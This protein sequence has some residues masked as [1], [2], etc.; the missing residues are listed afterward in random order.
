MSAGAAHRRAAG[1]L[2][3]AVL[4]LLAAGSAAAAADWRAVV[5]ELFP[6]A[7]LVGEMSGEPPVAE[8]RAGAEVVGHV[9][10]T[11]R[12]APVPAYSGEPI[13]ALLGIGAGGRLRG[14]RIVAHQ[15]PILA[16]GVSDRQLAE[17]VAQYRGLPADVRIQVGGGAREG[18]TVIDGLSGATITAMSV[19]ASIQATARQSAAALG[20]TGAAE[21]VEPV[22]KRNWRE[23]RWEIAVLLAALGLL[24]TVLVFQDAFARR[25]RL[26]TA[27]RRG[28]LVFTLGFIGWYALAQLSVVN[29]F[30]F[31]HAATGEFRWETF[32]VDPLLFLLWGFVAVAMLL[33]GRG[34]YCGWLC[35]Y[36]ALQELASL[37]GRRLGL[38]QWRFPTAVHDRLWALKYVLFL[39]LFGLALQSLVTVQPYL[40]VEPFKTAITLRFQREWPFVAY[41]ALFVLVSMFNPKFYCKYVCPLGAALAI[42]ARLRL[43]DWLRRRKECGRPCQVCAVE[44]D[45]QAIRATGEINVN[46]CH[47]CLDCQLLYYDDHRCPPLAERRRRREKSREAWEKVRASV[48]AQRT[49]DD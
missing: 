32:L 35:P 18:Y 47:H 3:A 24:T 26:V 23:R 40:E 7:T 5:P 19:D 25:P 36:G 34:V 31:L 49:G 11:D 30:T 4:T 38:P 46:E 43:L 20:L 1:R 33:W 39:G 22:W 16:A 6:E 2:P 41:A 13:S 37:L 44:C 12:V 8:V 29:V 45:V 9:A 42:P 27:I 28:F 48:P 21:A 15:E 17:F 14:V 10:L